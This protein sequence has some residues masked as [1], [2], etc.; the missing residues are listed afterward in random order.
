MGKQEPLIEDSELPITR[1]A[2]ANQKNVTVN[3]PRKKPEECPSCLVHKLT[4][5]NGVKDGW[6]PNKNL[7]TKEWRTFIDDERQLESN[8]AKYARFN[9]AIRL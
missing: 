2:S 5:S 9:A 6:I 8:E 3:I 4:H 1:A 7:Q